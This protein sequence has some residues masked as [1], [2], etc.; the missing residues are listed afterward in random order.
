MKRRDER[1]YYEFIA[2]FFC[3]G[4][5]SVIGARFLHTG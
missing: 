2:N 1:F 5:D 3:S 4:N